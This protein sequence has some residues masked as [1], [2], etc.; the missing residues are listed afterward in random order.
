M[1]PIVVF[2]LLAGVAA[3]VS[4]ENPLS[5]PWFPEA[6]T[7]EYYQ[8]D[9]PVQTVAIIG[10]GPSG[11][12]AFR[13]LTEAGLHVRIFERDSVPGGNWHYTEE[14][15]L[16]APVPNAP[17][18]IANFVPSLP[19]ACVDLPYSEEFQDDGKICRDHR[20]PK[21]MWE[22]LT[23]NS[24]SP[25]QQFPQWPWPAG[26]PWELSQYQVRNYLRSYASYHNINSNDENPAAA[27]STRVERVEKRIN[28]AGQEQG[29]RLWLRTLEPTQSNTYRATWWTEDFDA[30]VVA[31]GRNAP[32]MPS[33]PGLEEWVWRFPDLLRH[34]RQYRRPETYSNQTVLIIGA[35]TSGTEISRGLNQH[36]RKIYQ[37]FRP[38]NNNGTHSALENEF[39][40]I[41]KNTSL[42]GEI[43]RFLPLSD[44]SSIQSGHVE[45]KNGTILSGIDSVILA[46]GYRY[47][48]PFLPQYY[49]GAAY[50]PHA[51]STRTVAPFLPLDGSHIR[52]LYLDQFYVRDPTLAFLGVSSGTSSFLSAEYTAL[53]LAKVWTD[54]AMLP[55]TETMQALYDKTVEK[56]SK[57]P[58][59]LARIV[60][61]IGWLNKAAAKYGG[62]QVDGVPKYTTEVLRYWLIGHFGEPVQIKGLEQDEGVL[63]SLGLAQRYD[64]DLLFHA[65]NW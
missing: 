4:F 28:Q 8:F 36:A 12:V 31:T 10:A 6:E 39:R 34:S 11:L 42:V 16:D 46:T 52:D 56:R 60:Y 13:E 17:T 61:L 50:E 26:T 65:D 43:E 57:V 29:W 63:A 15:P 62:K 21:P 5:T 55:D 30:V 49:D 53:A 24:P 64:D 27:Y 2:V 59:Y 54:T 19:P 51:G 58:R 9:W 25:L 47:S 7:N 1:R 37:S 45:L 22:S 38:H 14:V 48:F 33:I 44:E 32:L 41:P 3:A 40:R 20:G 18:P 35:A 23:T